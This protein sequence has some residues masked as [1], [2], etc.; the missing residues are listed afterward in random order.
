MVVDLLGHYNEE[1]DTCHQMDEKEVPSFE[2]I[3]WSRGISSDGIS[4]RLSF[5]DSF[6]DNGLI[7]HFTVTV[8]PSH[9]KNEAHV[10]KGK[11]HRPKRQTRMIAI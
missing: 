3:P 8:V 10:L 2:N 11:E 1:E 5:N 6:L 7:L 9:V 4:V